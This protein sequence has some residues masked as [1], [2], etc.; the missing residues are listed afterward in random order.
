MISKCFLLCMFVKKLRKG[1]YVLCPSLLGDL[2]PAWL[3]DGHLIVIADECWWFSWP[4]TSG[5]LLTLISGGS[6]LLTVLSDSCLALAL[7]GVLT[8]EAVLLNMTECFC[9]S[10][11]LLWPKTSGFLRLKREMA[12]LRE[13]GQMMVNR[14]GV[15]RTSYGFMKVRNSSEAWLCSADWR[16]I[17]SNPRLPTLFGFWGR[18][19]QLFALNLFCLINGKELLPSKLLQLCFCYYD[20]EVV[21]QWLRL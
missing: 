12:A 21:A 15:S 2:R 8:T 3:G 1:V 20:V 11:I 4:L 9:A 5:G 7:D 14:E 17:I 19:A 16:D 13:S 6:F 10:G 18:T